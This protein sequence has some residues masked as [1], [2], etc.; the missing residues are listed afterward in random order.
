MGR[1]GRE[2]VVGCRGCSL[3]VRVGF[4][5]VEEEDG[6]ETGEERKG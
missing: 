6:E 1:G 2:V 5:V 3:W 4:A